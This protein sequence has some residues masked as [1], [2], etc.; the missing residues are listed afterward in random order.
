MVSIITVNYNGYRDT[1]ELITSLKQNETYPYEIIV[2]DNASKGDDANIIEQTFPEV[3]VVRSPVNLGFAGGNNLGYPYA[4]GEYIF[5]LNNDMI[6]RSP[7]LRP[8]VDRLERDHYA[9]VSPCI[10]FYHNP[11]YIQYY[12]HQDL[13]SIT[14]RHMTEAYDPTNDEHFLQPHET[15]ALHGGAM[16]VRRDVIEQAGQMTDVYFLFYEEFDWSIRIRRAGGHLFYEPASVVYHKES[17]SIR[18]LTPTREYYLIRAR[19]LYARR[20][21]RSWRKPLACL[22]L[23]L[24]ATPRRV[25]Q[26]LFKGRFRLA[27][28]VLRGAFSGLTKRLDNG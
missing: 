18:L 5:Y 6:V 9:G 7:M 26:H 12:G 1:C 23:L 2:V 3:I 27:A 24:I 20:N 13:T 22:Y 16:M 17:M 14:V 21:S 10:R 11:D 15:E 19:I 28:S 4:K 25:V 8:L